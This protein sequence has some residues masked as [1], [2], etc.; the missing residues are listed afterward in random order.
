MYVLNQLFAVQPN[1]VL[2]IQK[3][4]FTVICTECKGTAVHCTACTQATVQVQIA[5]QQDMCHLFH[6]KLNYFKK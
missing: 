4:L 6:V 5:K 3:Q 1:H 2:N